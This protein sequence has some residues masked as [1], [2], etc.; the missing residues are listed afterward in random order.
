MGERNSA[1]GAAKTTFHSHSVSPSSLIRGSL[2]AH[3]KLAAKTGLI[4]ECE[5]VQDVVRTSVESITKVLG[6]TAVLRASS[7]ENRHETSCREDWGNGTAQHIQSQFVLPSAEALA[8]PRSRPAIS[9]QASA[10]TLLLSNAVESGG[11]NAAQIRSQGK[12]TEDIKCAARD[13][14]EK[15]AAEGRRRSQSSNNPFGKQKAKRATAVM[16]SGKTKEKEGGRRGSVSHA[17]DAKLIITSPKGGRLERLRER[18]LAVY[19]GWRT[20][21]VLKREEIQKLVRELKS[22]RTKQEVVKETKQPGITI[23]NSAYN[24]KKQQF[25]IIFTSKMRVA[26]K[27]LP[28]RQPSQHLLTYGQ[29][30]REGRPASKLQLDSGKALLKELQQCRS[31]P[32]KK[33]VP[34]KVSQNVLCP[35]TL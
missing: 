16:A 14:G 17:Q 3:L 23:I 27:T 1:A 20:R 30:V 25:H 33:P 7:K 11:R 4:E 2:V 13:E 31:G 28:K 22:L 8:R 21:R 15:K 18:L 35:A 9:K 24:F 19:K 6:S 26:E 5:R 32:G 34:A 29:I 12:K 10:T